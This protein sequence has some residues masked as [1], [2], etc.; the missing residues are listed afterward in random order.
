MVVWGGNGLNNYVVLWG[1]PSLPRKG[2]GISAIGS[3]QT[4]GLAMRDGARLNSHTLSS[5]PATAYC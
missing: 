1:R 5:G 3:G 2:K 4:L